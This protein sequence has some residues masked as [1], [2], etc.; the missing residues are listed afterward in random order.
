VTRASARRDAGGGPF[1]CV[2]Q[3]PQIPQIFI[4]V[5]DDGKDETENR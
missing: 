1:L 3:I 2:T 4:F 5:W